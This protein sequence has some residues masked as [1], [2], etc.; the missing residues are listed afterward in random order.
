MC[1]ERRQL[2]GRY[3]KVQK[4]IKPNDS[5]SKMLKGINLRIDGGKMTE[6]LIRETIEEDLKNV[7]EL[8]NTGDVMKYVGFPNGLNITYIEIEKW[9]Y[10]LKD[11]PNSKHYSIYDNSVGYCGETYY[12]IDRKHALATLDIKLNENARGKGIAYTALLNT[13]DIIFNNNLCEKAFVDP[14]IEN[15]KA[16]KLYEKI[17]FKSTDRPKHLEPYEVYLEIT[18]EEYIERK[19]ELKR[20]IG[21]K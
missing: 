14:N 8:W 2:T 12:S 18:R 16:W 17:G 4:S 11:K 1:A 5:I 3:M 19:K 10:N 9:F 13:L 6:L 7:M 15:K 21:V 20:T